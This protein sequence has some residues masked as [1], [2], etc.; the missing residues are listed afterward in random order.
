MGAAARLFVLGA[1]LMLATV[2]SAVAQQRGSILGR[3]TDPDGL[4]LPGATV[5]VTNAATG[6]T[7]TTVT[8]DTGAYSVPNLEPGTYAVSVEM[9]GFAEL[10]RAD[11]LLTAGLNVTMDFKMQVAGVREEVVVTGESPLVE[12]TSNQI[13]GSLSR[14]EI[15]DVPSNFRNF[16]A[17]TQLIPGITPNPAASTFEG[18][19]VVANGTPSQ[20]NVY[21]LDGMYNNDDRLGGSQGTQVRVVLDN[22]EEYQVLSNQYSAEYGGGA[23]AIIN[24]VTRGGTNAFNGRAYTYFR[25]D[26][27]N[28]RNA[29]LP[30]DAPKPPERTLQSGFG[31]GGPII[32]NRAHFYFTIE[33]DQ[34]QIAGFKTFPAAAAPLATDMLGEFSVDA[35]N[36]FARGDLQINPSH[37]LN[38]RWLLETAPTKGEGFNTNNQTPDAQTWESDWDHMLSGTYTA[39]LTDRASNVIRLGRISEDLAT[40]QQTYFDDDVNFIGFAGRDPLSIPQSNVHPGYVTGEGGSMVNTIIHTYVFDE[41]FSYFVP[42]LWGREHNFK[43]GGG[44][45]FN[46]MEPRTTVDSGTFQFRGDAPY[47]PNDLATYPFQFEIAIG[48]P[49]V[50]GFDVYSRDKRYYFFAE[51]KWRLADNLTLNLGLRYDHQRQ[52]P[53][54]SDDFGPRVGFAWDVFGTGKTVVRG[55]AGK[56]YNYVPVVLDLTHQ[57]SGLITQ[58][59]TITVADPN[60]PVLRP[61]MITDSAGNPGVAVLSAA[62]QA[63]INALRGTA[64]NRNPRLD[65]D[66]RQMPYQWSWSA[67]ISHELFA[68]AALSLDYVANASRD[69]IGVVDINEPVDGV[70]PGVNGFDPNGELIPPEAR[71]VNYQRVL[72]TQTRS[73]FDG[74]YKSLQVSFQRR[75]A[76]RWSARVAYTVQKSNYVGIGNPDARRVWLDND[77]RADYGRFTS[78]R[79]QV[80]AMSGTYNPWRALTVAGV[81]S[82][83]TGAPINETVGTDVNRDNDNNDRPIRG[84]NDLTRPILS[85]VDSQGR[86]VINGLKGPESVLFDISFRYQ[87]PL[88]K[89][90]DSLD[91]FYDIFNLFN[92]TN[93]V[94][95]TGNRNTTVFMVPTAA[96]F[97]RQMQFGVRLRF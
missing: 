59:P 85:E 57:Q 17:L 19:Q 8:A 97:P 78:D 33:N 79:R 83:T 87:L 80:L 36:Y 58:F 68:N 64:F 56:F 5:T 51:D 22:I 43:V 86:A 30:D 35:M 90:F 73:E 34:E 45:S 49:S 38:V 82:A 21:L 60:S 3:I 15:E 88:G 25:D 70:R 9:P 28:A 94:A 18:G 95:P 65:S 77:I 84:V 69:Q 92:R 50:N 44:I 47:N 13:G 62:G 91:L 66:G 31:L 55:G 61:D 63:T 37:F 75:I 32:R 11:L 24:M 89:G 27:F 12:T 48:P 76:N 96:Q 42:E 81:L 54:S 53:A 1:C 46:R 41:S 10:K 39:V 23:G 16:T 71:N 40:G 6:F 74:N 14:K 93:Y 29:F 4:P 67:G 52:T 2:S 7:R 20:Q 72:Q 26:T